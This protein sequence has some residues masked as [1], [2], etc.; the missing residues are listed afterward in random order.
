MGQYAVT[1]LIAAVLVIF[2]IYQQLRTR[3]I[4]SR[5]L[6]VLPLILAGLGIVNISHQPPASAAADTALAASVITGVLFGVARGITTKIWWSEGVMMRKG[7]GIT[8]ALWIVGIGL[9]LVIGLIARRNGVA[10]SVTTG[11]IP[12]FLGITLAAQNL[13]I[14]LHAQDLPVSSGE[15]AQ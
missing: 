12:L 2:I 8:L 6:V 10:V 14:W 4:T 3:P 13:L 7:T 1:I 11:E 5:Q 9:R 15:L